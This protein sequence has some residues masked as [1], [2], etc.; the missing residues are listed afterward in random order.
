MAT[1]R[2]AVSHSLPNILVGAV[3]VFE[4]ENVGKNVLEKSPFA[5]DCR[6][7]VQD[8][9]GRFGRRRDSPDTRS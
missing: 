9:R 3:E 5:G 8:P 6:G 2:P 1:T 7:A 4:Q